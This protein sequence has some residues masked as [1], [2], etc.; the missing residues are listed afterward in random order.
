MLDVVF[1][2]ILSNTWVVQWILI[3]TS[4]TSLTVKIQIITYTVFTVN[5]Q[6]KGS[7]S[8]EYHSTNSS[9][10]MKIDCLLHI[11]IRSSPWSY[12]DGFHRDQRFFN[13]TSSHLSKKNN[14][15]YSENP[16]QKHSGLYRS[17]QKAKVSAQRFI[18]CPTL[19]HL[20]SWR[21]IDA[22]RIWGSHSKTLLGW[23]SFA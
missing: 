17:W 23:L 10:T 13:Y 5:W 15:N 11:K 8:N 2:W 14:Y 16:S 22:K 12:I 18:P 19:F 4:H 7:T 9:A 20:L 1:R 3:H 6:V 21:A